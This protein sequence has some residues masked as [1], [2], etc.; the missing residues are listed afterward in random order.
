MLSLLLQDL[1]SI[2]D[3]GERHPYS[4]YPRKSNT[5]SARGLLPPLEDLKVPDLKLLAIALPCFLTN[6][7]RRGYPVVSQSVK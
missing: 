2:K 6:C 1:T 3:L 7:E 4:L 5:A